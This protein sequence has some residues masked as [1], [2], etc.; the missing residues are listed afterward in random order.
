MGC[1]AGAC[2]PMPGLALPAF[3]ESW[4]RVGYAK[5]VARWSMSRTTAPW[6]FLAPLQRCA[7]LGR[8][9]TKREK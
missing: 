1:A 9:K 2:S 7:L 4:P 6:Q 5:H 8:A 3:A